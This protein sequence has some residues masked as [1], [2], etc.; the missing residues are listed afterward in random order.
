MDEMTSFFWECVLC[1]GVVITTRAGG[2]YIGEKGLIDE[3]P[4]TADV[5]VKTE[6]CCLCITRANFDQVRR[7]R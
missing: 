6:C 5:L 3:T 4:R 2:S 7:S 1:V